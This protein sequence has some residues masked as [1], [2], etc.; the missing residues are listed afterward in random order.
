LRREKKSIVI[1]DW[2]R[3]CTFGKRKAAKYTVSD[4]IDIA[5]LHISKQNHV[6]GS[7]DFNSRRDVGR[8]LFP[9]IWLVKDL[10]KAEMA[11]LV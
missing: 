7:E 4:V 5:L 9:Q 8:Q 11:V 10:M 2:V 1:I 6:E 3:V